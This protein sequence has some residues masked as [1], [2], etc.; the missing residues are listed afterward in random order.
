MVSLEDGTKNSVIFEALKRRIRKWVWPYIRYYPGIFFIDSV[1]SLNS[2]V[3]ISRTSAEIE[4]HNIPNS[5]QDCHLLDHDV[6]S[7]K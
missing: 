7:C 1:K 6:P 3:R 2:S 5:K 4:T